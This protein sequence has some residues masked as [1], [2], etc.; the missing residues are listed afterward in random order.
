MD[1]SAALAA[2]LDWLFETEQP[3]ASIEHGGLMLAAG[4]SR[5]LS[6][7]P[8]GHTA[9][10]VVVID[11][12]KPEWIDNG[13]NKLMTLANP[14][15]VTELDDLAQQIRERGYAVAST[16]NG[17]PGP[18]GSVGL[19]RA[20]H[21]SLLAAAERYRAGCPDHR[22]VFCGRED[23]CGWYSRGS[24]LIRRPVAAA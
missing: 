11:V 1:V 9:P 5:R 18:S 4:A 13:P 21:P 23:G 15:G 10:S 19:E 24:S 3:N 2:G 14:I 12:V 22:S 16:W 20:A 7:S 6:F 17:H 8:W